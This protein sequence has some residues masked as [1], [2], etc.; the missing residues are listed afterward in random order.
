MARLMQRHPSK[1]L[2]REEGRADVAWARGVRSMKHQL[3]AIVF[4]IL[5]TTFSLSVTLL[6]MYVLGRGALSLIRIGM[7]MV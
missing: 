7:G 1:S 4:G 2:Y 6:G 3:L 5:L